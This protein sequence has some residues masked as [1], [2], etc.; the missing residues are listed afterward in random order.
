MVVRGKA[1]GQDY[2]SAPA[3]RLMRGGVMAGQLT[4]GRFCR[5]VSER[6]ENN[7]TKDNDLPLLHPIDLTAATRSD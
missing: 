6:R 4:S 7:G 1:M 3:R 2:A 5:K